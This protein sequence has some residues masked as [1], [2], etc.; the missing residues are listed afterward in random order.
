MR[1]SM[2]VVEGCLMFLVS[3]SVSAAS[4]REALVVNAAWLAA[5]LNDPGL[6]LLHVGKK[7]DYASAHIPGARSVSQQ[8]VSVS[9]HEF[10]GNGLMLEMPGADALRHDLESLGISDNSRVVVYYGKDWVSPTT[11][12]MFTLD[13][14]GLGANSSLLDGG[15]DAW[16]RNGG[17]V[18]KDV[19]AP[20][21]GTLAPLKIRPIVVDA[22]YVR[23]N[24]NT[25][26]VAIVD[27]RDGAFY[28]GVETG[29]SMGHTHRTGHIA[30][31]HS[32]PFTS[33]TDDQVML[34][35][36]AALAEL[37]T[38]AGVKPDD[39]V[40]G[41]CHIGQQTTAMLFAARTLGHRVLLYDGSFEDWSRHE[42]Y[43][44][45]NPSAKQGGK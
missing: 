40:I 34:K 32:V 37:F 22:E 33:I 27:G 19:P 38:K 7:E 8:D 39:T 35:S 26:H 12:I 20:M 2:T 5:H 21:T 15:M 18:T 24:L 9:D 36:P 31:A 6:V 17:V 42:G 16:I 13:Y 14:A 45:D 30:G 4:P 43:P 25:A 3:L 28:D 1:K 10:K 41:Y 23:K 44:V 11:R 29:D